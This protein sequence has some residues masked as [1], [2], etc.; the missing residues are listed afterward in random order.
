MAW[1]FMSNVAAGELFLEKARHKYFQLWG[2]YHLCHNCSTLPLQG[3]H[4]HRQGISEWARL[5]SKTIFRQKQ[6]GGRLGPRVVIYCLLVFILV[7]S[8]NVGPCLFSSYIFAPGSSPV[9]G[10]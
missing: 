3:K 1:S 10:T 9:P 8:M 7:P 4:N 2:L 6:K 5:C